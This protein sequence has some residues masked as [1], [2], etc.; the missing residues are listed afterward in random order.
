MKKIITIIIALMPVF[1]FAQSAERQVI[2]SAGGTST[3]TDLKVSS[4][5]GEA[6]VGTGTSSTIIL[7]QGFQQ[8]GEGE[9][10]I[11]DTE[12]GL[13]VNVYPNPSKG[14]VTLDMDAP[15]TLE[16]SVSVLDFNGTVISQPVQ[17]QKVHGSSTHE[18]D[19][20]SLAAGN[21]FIQ[22]QNSKGNLKQT[23]KIVKVD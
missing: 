10:G 11:E 1:L 15:N 17:K 2:G 7:T 21:Y 13:S 9:L 19:L 8:P 12:T 3:T 6:V 16:I 20:S 5:V 14:I 23:I 18:I 4:T 22:L